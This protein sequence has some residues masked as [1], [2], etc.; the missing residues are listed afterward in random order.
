MPIVY[1]DFSSQQFRYLV[2]KLFQL[3]SKNIMGCENVLLE[4]KKGNYC[5][6]LQSNKKI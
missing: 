1:H 5:Q 4:N 6:K 2:D 3:I